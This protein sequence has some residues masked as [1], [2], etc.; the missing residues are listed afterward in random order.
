MRTVSLDYRDTLE[1][2]QWKLITFIRLNPSLN[3]NIVYKTRFV[4]VTEPAIIFNCY[5]FK[6]GYQLRFIEPDFEK[7]CI[8][9]IKVIKPVLLDFLKEVRY[10]GLAF[11]VIIKYKSE[12]YS[13]TFTVFN[14]S[15]NESLEG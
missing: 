15:E 8:E 1:L 5:E 7:Y 11:T 4:D 9:F 2:L 3:A 14:K 13:K 10:G 12:N 6:E